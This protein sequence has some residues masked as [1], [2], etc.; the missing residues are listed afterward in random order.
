MKLKFKVQEYNRGDGTHHWEAID[1]LNNKKIDFFKNNDGN[2]DMFGE[3]PS[4]QNYLLNEY[5]IN[6]LLSYNATNRDPDINE[7]HTKC[8]W[9]F[10][11][12]KN[13]EVEIIDI[14][15]SYAHMSVH[16]F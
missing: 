11:D 13:N 5:N 3:Y 2:G 14:P 16:K 9:T 12:D 10:R 8:V 4:I 1:C 7:K 6:M 15:R